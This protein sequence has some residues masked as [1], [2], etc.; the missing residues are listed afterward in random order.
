MI[1]DREMRVNKP[2]CSPPSKRMTATLGDGISTSTGTFL[3]VSQ[4]MMTLQAVRREK[5][6]ATDRGRLGLQ[7]SHS[8]AVPEVLLPQ[9]PDVIGVPAVLIDII[10][11]S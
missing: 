8:E 11:V 6:R 10:A 3:I 5:L 1:E 9:Y 7:E 2:C 4:G